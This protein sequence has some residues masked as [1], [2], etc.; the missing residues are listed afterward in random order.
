MRGL[1]RRRDSLVELLEPAA[2][3]PP[4]L[5]IGEIGL[6]L[7]GLYGSIDFRQGRLRG[8][9]V[10]FFSHGRKLADLSGPIE[11]LRGLL[12]VRTVRRLG[13]RERRDELHQRVDAGIVVSLVEMQPGDSLHWQQQ[14]GVFDAES[15]EGQKCL[16]A[17]FSL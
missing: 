6:P 7:V 12:R 16:G 4:A 2:S 11:D 9:V 1:V 17:F 10:L 15:L 5:F 14:L 8:S 3:F 13:L